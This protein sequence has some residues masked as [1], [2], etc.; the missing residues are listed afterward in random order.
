MGELCTQDDLHDPD[1]A[2]MTRKDYPPEQAIGMLR[3]AEVRLSQRTAR[4]VGALASRSRASTGGGS[5]MAG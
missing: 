1:L 2:R 3:E 5:R 4:F